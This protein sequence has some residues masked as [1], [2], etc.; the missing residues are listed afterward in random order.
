MGTVYE[1]IL[2]EESRTLGCGLAQIAALN[3]HW[4][5]IHYRDQF[6]SPMA[7]CNKQKHRL[8]AVFLLGGA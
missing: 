7:K 4:T 8:M 2:A 1:Q 6:D 5:F 3:V